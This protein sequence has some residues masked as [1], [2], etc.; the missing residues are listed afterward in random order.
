MNEPQTPSGED[1]RVVFKT[2]DFRIVEPRHRSPIDIN[3]TVLD[4]PKILA[5]V[6]VCES[7]IAAERAMR[8]SIQND[9]ALLS[10]EVKRLAA[11]VV[12]LENELRHGGGP[13]IDFEKDEEWCLNE[14]W[15]EPTSSGDARDLSFRTV[16][17]KSGDEFVT[18]TQMLDADGRIVMRI[19]K[20]RS[21]EVTTTPAITVSPE[22]E[23]TNGGAMPV[24]TVKAAPH[25]EYWSDPNWGE[26]TSNHSCRTIRGK[27]GDGFVSEVQCID[28]EGRI[29]MRSR[30][31]R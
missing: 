7:Q 6:V 12:S 27:P 28:P 25:L 19:R 21:A 9:V 29:V 15:R 16:R 23:A 20:A 24:G 2:D 3:V 31:L 11:M 18:E 1:A 13:E 4:D 30:W 17:R 8:Q 26:N 14:V 5:H 10:E 22:S